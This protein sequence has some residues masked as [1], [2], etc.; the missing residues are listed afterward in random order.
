MPGCRVHEVVTLEYDYR[1]V[2]ALL[3]VLV[4]FFLHFLYDWCKERRRKRAHLKALYMEIRGALRVLS[5]IRWS[6]D[7]VHILPTFPRE[8]WL[9]AKVAG[10]VDPSDPLFLKI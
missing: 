6:A 2:S 1:V 3:G 10:V 5:G 8:A 9:G 4:G 7:S